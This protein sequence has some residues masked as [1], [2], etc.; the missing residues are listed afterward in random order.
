MPEVLLDDLNEA[1]RA[2]V[3]HT[4]GPLLVVAGAGTGKTTVLTRR[5]AHLLQQPEMDPSRILAL[6]FTDKAAGEMEDRILQLLPVGT[7]DFWI[8]TFH[9]FCQRVLEAHGLEIGL[10]HRFRVLTPTDAWLLLRRHLPELPLQHYKPLGNPIKFLRSLLQHI[11]RAKDEGIAPEAYKEFAET[12]VLEG[13]DV[14]VASERARL[15]ELSELYGVYRSL[16]LQEDS[17]D[18]GDLILETLRLFRERP[19]VLRYYQQ[20]FK[21]I[22]VDEFQDTNWAQYELVKMLAGKEHQLTVVGDDDQAIYK[23]RGASLANILQFRTDFPEAKTVTL[24]ENYRSKKEILDIA[25]SF[26]CH[27]NPH[28]LEV[29]LTELG[30]TKQLRAM[31]GDGG[32]V[33][34][35][36]ERSIIEETERVIERMKAI[37]KRSDSVHWNDFAILVRS[38]DGAEPFIQALDQARIP[39]QFLALRGLYTKP[40][41]IDVLSLL[42]LLDGFYE[43]SAVWR[44]LTLPG[45]EVTGKD[46]AELVQAATKKAVP[47][48]KELLKVVER[49]PGEESEALLTTHAKEGI[50]KLVNLITKS[51]EEAKRASAFHAFK[52]ILDES[53]YLQHLLTLP[54]AEKIEK[55]R[56]LNGFAERIKRYE[57]MSLSPS[58][59]GFLEEFRL[60]LESGEE[61]ALTA[62]PES[63]PDMVKIM[64]VHAAKGLEFPYVFVVSMVDQRFPSRARS[65]AIP[66]PTGLVKERLPEGDYHI[67]EERRLF[68][69]AMTRAKQ[70]LYCTGAINYGG[71][72]EK[73]PSPFVAEAGFTLP[74]MSG[75]VFDLTKGLVITPQAEDGTHTPEL[76]HYDLKRSFSF[77]QLAAFDKCPLQYKFAYI[78]RIPILGSFQRS[79]G[80]SIHRTFELL[81]RV[82]LAGGTLEAVDALSIFKKCWLNEWYSD[83]A[84]HDQ[85]FTLG[86]QATLHFLRVLETEKPPMKELELPFTLVLGKHSLKGRIDRVDLLPDGS[87]AIYDYKTGEAKDELKA[88]DKKQLHLYQIA[89]EKEGKKVSRLVYVYVKEWIEREVEVLTEK[90]KATLLEKI[91]KNMEEILRSDFSPTPE[92]HICRTCDF[93]QICEFKRL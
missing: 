43:S 23:F 13:D 10:P 66:L 29:S 69:V 63:G 46:L 6:T 53:G 62:D 41:I 19:A 47:L 68:Y 14:E 31:N 72:R 2:A 8:S 22:L 55:L 56:H 39:F 12:A 79:F 65:E 9:G 38:N 92:A 91:E 80:Q 73:K 49:K 11:S 67:E 83:S 74:E 77:S 87:Y 26:I 60:E 37:K 54:E 89:F 36:W 57:Q 28:R 76:A 34:L 30:L 52:K 59:S 18:F 21:S 35:F 7:Y 75:S 88:S 64:T 48:W 27:N 16:M 82:Y 40:V 78:F 32:A 20:Q 50:A 51:S 17:L 25:Y 61:G 4:A 42:S 5:Y 15:K 58:L 3:T 81:G 85:W 45:I 24:V 44:A 86:E 93:R 90:G 1:Q 84:H 70:E 71:A 33:E